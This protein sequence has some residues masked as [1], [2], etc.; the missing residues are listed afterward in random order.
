MDKKKILFILIL[1]SLPFFAMALETDYPA[2]GGTQPTDDT[3]PAEFLKY[4]FN[5]G[6]LFGV[7]AAVFVIISQGAT[8]LMSKGET[9]L[10]ILAKE[11]IKRVFVGLLILLG[12]YVIL[13]A[14]NP[15]LKVIKFSPLEV[16]ENI[17]NGPGTE[18]EA[19]PLSE[20]EEI[21]LG[22]ILESI[23]AANSSERIYDDKTEELCY[24][25][26]ENGD[27]VDRNDDKKIDDKDLLKGM[28]MYYCLSELN[29]AIIK[30]IKDLNGGNSLCDS[31][32]DGGPIEEMKSLIT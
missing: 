23:L 9:A 22:S 11:N 10:V 25:Y 7:I 26:D 14:I 4:I 32:A 20:F 28:D 8:M 24:S 15:D 3:S 27:T 30:K 6:I 16:F 19:Y 12:A 13:T 21:P 5:L 1:L 29:K 18:E 17:I 31:L 2:M